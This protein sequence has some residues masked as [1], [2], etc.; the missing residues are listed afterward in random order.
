MLSLDHR[1]LARESRL[2]TFDLD[3]DN[4]SLAREDK[5]SIQQH[6][7]LLARNQKILSVA[8]QLEQVRQ[9]AAAAQGDAL[10]QVEQIGAAAAPNN[11]EESKKAK[12]KR[13][14]C[15]PRHTNEKRPADKPNMPDA[16]YTVWSTIKKEK[17]GS[18]FTDWDILP[19]R[20]TKDLDGRKSGR[21]REYIN[22]P[23]AV[24]PGGYDPI[25]GEIPDPKTKEDEFWCFCKSEMDNAN[26]QLF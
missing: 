10:Q 12:W 25:P 9:I 11:D 26:P 6:R 22:D 16:S 13:H 4:R 20:T 3:G 23:N 1:N 14:H 15:T 18:M 17:S 21:K 7:T 24:K 19:H 5:V 8:L 2:L